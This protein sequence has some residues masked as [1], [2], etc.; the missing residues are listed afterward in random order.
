LADWPS[1]G[2]YS[3]AVPQN[4]SSLAVVA[5]VAVLAPILG[6]YVARVRIPIVVLELLLG[7]LV[8]PHVLKLATT[9]G[10]VDTLATFGLAFLFFLSGLEIDFDRVRGRPIEL[11]GLGWLVSVALG[12]GVAAILHAEGR[13]IS[14]LVIGLC[15]VTTS[16]GTLIPTLKDD[17]LLG[18]RFGVFVVGAG[19]IG[20]FGPI[21]LVS[22]LLG[23]NRAGRAAV[24]L[25]VFTAIAVAAAVLALRWRPTRV[26]A[27]VQRTMR[28]SEQLAVRLSWLLL[29]LLLYVTSRFGLDVILGAFA[30]GLVVGLVAQGPESDPVRAGLDAIGYGVFIPVFFVASGMNLDVGALFSSLGT[31]LRLPAFLVLLLIV[32]GLPAV[33][34][35]R[36]LPRTDLIP[37]AL[38]SA[39]AFPLIVAITAIA[40]ETGQI[41]PAYSVALIGAGVV[42]ISVFPMV[43]FALRREGV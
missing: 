8:G 13:I 10:I 26:V 32:R 33:L 5:T 31:A 20:E 17:D 37:L 15:L 41:K 14:T 16:L 43:A 34:Y 4:L 6:D 2:L 23:V 21:V 39:T 36:E 24:F 22:L 25:A 27:L 9:S 40:V 7:I 28:R 12:F 19:T 35:R 11:A 38:L 42:S 18:T 29:V 1:N 30:A 3:R